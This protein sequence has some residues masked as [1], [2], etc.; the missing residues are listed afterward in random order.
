VQGTIFGDLT[1]EQTLEIAYRL[2][3]YEGEKPLDRISQ[4]G[5]SAEYVR[6][7]TKRAV[8]GVSSKVKIWPGIDIDIP[9]AA[10]EKKT[11]PDDVY[12]AVKA[13]LEAGAHGVLLSRKYSEMTLANLRAAGRAVRDLKLA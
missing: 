12:A 13:A 8:A 6:R 2:Q 4:Q 9:T 1:P 3:Q 11:Q 10:N 7:E 5:L